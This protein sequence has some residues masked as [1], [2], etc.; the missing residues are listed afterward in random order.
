MAAK[1]KSSKKKKRTLIVELRS[2]ASTFKKTAKKN[3]KMEGGYKKDG[4]A[5]GKITK[6]CYDPIVRKH[7][8]FEEKKVSK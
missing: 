8:L 1:K 7:V 2:T 3:P 6:M 4:V 5:T